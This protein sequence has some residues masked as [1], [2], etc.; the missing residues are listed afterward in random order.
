G[1][2]SRPLPGLLAPLTHELVE[3]AR[4]VRRFDEVHYARLLDLGGPGD[5]ARTTTKVLLSCLIVLVNT[6]RAAEIRAAAFRIGRRVQTDDRSSN[7]GR[8]VHRAGVRAQQNVGALQE[9][10]QLGKR[11]ATDR[12]EYWQLYHSFDRLRHGALDFRGSPGQHD[13]HVVHA[14]R[15]ICNF[16][17]VLRAPVA[18]GVARARTDDERRTLV[19]DDLRGIVTRIP[20]QRDIP[21]QQ[22]VV[23]AER[24]GEAE[25]RVHNVLTCA[26]RD[27]MSRAQPLQLPRPGTVEGETP[28]RAYVAAE[29][30][31]T[32]CELHMQQQIEALLANR[33]TK[34]LEVL[35][36][37]T[38]VED[39][40]LDFRNEAKKLC[41]DL[42]DD[43]REAHFRPG[44]LE[45]A[46]HRQHVTDIADGREP[47]DAD[48]ARGVGENHWNRMTASCASP[49]SVVA[50]VRRTPT[51]DGAMLY[52]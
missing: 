39:D 23:H 29:E 22:A 14:R 34:V 21:A 37:V 10:K 15:V 33:H 4:D 18:T 35:K 1:S 12:V 7:G 3:F 5:F 38:L 44:L 9:R 47:Q 16:G 51:R 32:Q 25:E 48:I 42:A 8:H 52:D 2:Y 43:P 24:L 30:A 17:V 11:I 46:H 28:R 26:R 49:A 45:S 13:P 20:R 40:K 41:L 50:D 6:P 19:V 36:R 27:A 31:G